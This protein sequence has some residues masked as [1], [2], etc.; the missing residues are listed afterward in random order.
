VE[1]KT[2]SSNSS[3]TKRKK[4]IKEGRKGEKERGVEEE[5]RKEKLEE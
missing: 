4:I 1:L 5:G 2:L 3:T